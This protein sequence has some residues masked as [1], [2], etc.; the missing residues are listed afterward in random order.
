MIIHTLTSVQSGKSYPLQH[1][2]DNRDNTKSI[3]LKSI[4][5]WVGWYNLKPKQY[6]TIKNKK[7]DLEEGLYN[8]NDIK[9]ILANENIDLTVNQSN[10]IATIEIP[11]NTSFEM[12]SNISSLLGFAP[13]NK[14]L[15]SG[16]HTGNT[17]INFAKPKEL[18]IFL[19]LFH[20]GLNV[21]VMSC[22]HNMPM[23]L[24]WKVLN[25]CCSW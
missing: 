19:E 20:H 11:Q 23:Q 14:V 1:Y 7:I 21:L 25:H 6:F 24:Q 8:F 18:L 10:G 13:K 4:V 9:D 5:Y 3:A 17:I 2:I 15:T 16:R 22:V 12:S